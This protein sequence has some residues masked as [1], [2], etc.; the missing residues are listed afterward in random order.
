MPMTRPTL[1]AIRDQRHADVDANLP[2]A[3][4]RLRRS[5]LEILVRMFAWAE[6]ALYGYIDFISRQLFPDLAERVYL[7]RWASLW[8]LSRTAA[9]FA[10]GAVTFAGTNGVVIPT[11]TLVRRSDGTEYETTASGTI[12]GGSANVA[13]EAIE[14]GLDGN[15]ATGVV[16]TLVSPIASVGNNPTVTAPGIAGGSDQE[17]D[18]AL[19]ARILS[20]MQTPPHGGSAADY[21]RWALEVPG[22]TRA[23]VIQPSLATVLAYNPAALADPA[24]DVLGTEFSAAGKAFVEFICAVGARTSGTCNVKINKADLASANDADASGDIVEGALPAFA[25]ANQ[26]GRFVVKVDAAKPLLTVIVDDIGDPVFAAFSAIAQHGL[27]EVLLLFV[28]D[29][30]GIGSAILPDSTEVSNVQAYID[31]PS[32][33]PVTAM[34]R[35]AAPTALTVNFDIDVTPNTA[36]VQAAVEAELRDLLLREGAPGVTIPLSHIREAISIA[37]GETDYVL[38]T[39]SA[40]ITPTATQIPIPGTFTF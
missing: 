35:A 1:T 8:A 31:D 27:A 28:R 32:R 37:V 25:A 4:S 7:E 3:D 17:D 9:T 30:D 29:G 36:E 6:H 38:N 33:R 5:V 11:G 22:V 26:V 19:R 20:R 18:E 16:L 40:A 10:T 23:W 39:P 14:G 15:A 13:V 12:S 34:F 2:G 21:V 24:A